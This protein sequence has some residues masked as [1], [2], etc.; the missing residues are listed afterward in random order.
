MSDSTSRLPARPSLEQL[1]KQAKDLLRQYRV[2]DKAAVDRFNAANPRFDSHDVALPE[3]TLADAQ[4]VIAREYG[5]ETWAKLKHHVET[6]RPAGREKYEQLAKTLADAYSAGDAMAVRNI[7]W[8]N[9]TSFVWEH[10][11]VDMQRHLPNWFASDNRT[12]ELALADAQDIVAHSYGFENWGKFTASFHLPPADPRSAPIF[13]NP[14]PPFYK[15]DWIENCIT[16]Q[17]LQSDNDWDAILAVIEDHGITKL[18]ASGITD[19]AMQR[20]ADLDHI[21]ELDIGGS[22]TLTDDGVRHLARMPQLQVLSM[23]GWTSP[24]TDRGLS[25]LRHLPELRRFGAGWTQGITDAGLATRS[26]SFSKR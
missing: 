26:V 15:I 21:T 22:K 16:V 1:S 10:K 14:R 12:P 23:G 8:N 4:F 18:T 7:N 11:A 5:F 13:M 25:V 17:G 20:L 2:S 19:A 3:A 6:I 24:I 9:G